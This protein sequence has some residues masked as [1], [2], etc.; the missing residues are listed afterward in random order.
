MTRAP[1]LPKAALVEMLSYRR[2]AFSKT[3]RKFIRD[4]LRPLDVE[5]DSFGNLYKRIG[6]APIMW[7][8]HTDTVHTQ[9]GIQTLCV[10]NDVVR[11]A[12]KAS[13]CLGGDNT[14]GVWLMAEMIRAGKPGLYIF[15]RSEELGGQ[16]SYHIAET[17]P[18]L[19]EGI[20]FAIAFDRRGT[21]SVITHQ[22][23]GRCCSDV[24]ASSL[25][26]ALGLGH[27]HDSGGTF[28]DTAS[29]MYLIGECTNVSAGFSNEHRA[30]ETVDLAYALDLRTSLLAFDWQALA[31]ERNPDDPDDDDIEKAWDIWGDEDQSPLRRSESMYSI[32]R[33]YPAEVADWLE[34]FGVAPEE[35]LEAIQA[36]HGTIRKR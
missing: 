22:A 33:D 13:N 10:A 9:G 2:P 34:G 16:G 23:G 32:V 35:I 25:A 27:V 12:D 24:F 11:V 7:S 15:H 19:V 36:S 1:M 18:S 21:Q 6:D 26:K 17:N 20:K 5:E 8:C 30:T 28:T 29:Y 14:V 4:Y 3:E 31:Y